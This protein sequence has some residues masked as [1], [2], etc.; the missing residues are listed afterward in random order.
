M[1]NSNS[2]LYYIDYVYSFQAPKTVRELSVA[3]SGTGI[4]LMQVL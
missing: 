1:Y 3:A 2:Y 4:C